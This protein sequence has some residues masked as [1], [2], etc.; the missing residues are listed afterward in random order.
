MHDGTLFPFRSSWGYLGG[1]WRL[2]EDEV[3]WSDLEDSTGII[4]SGPADVLVTVFRGRNRKQQALDDVPV[5]FK[6]PKLADHGVFMNVRSKKEKKALDKEIPYSKIAESDKQAYLEAEAK[7]WQSWL[8]YDAV[9][10]LSVEESQEILRTKRERVLKCR[11]VYRNKHAGLVDAA[12]NPLPLKPKARLCVQGQHDPDCMSGLVKLDAPTVQHTSFM[13]FLHLVVSYGWIDFLRNGDI[14]SAFLQGEETTGEPLYMF[15]PERGLPNLNAQQVLRL[16]RPVYGRP[17]APRAWYNQI[18][19]FIMNNMGYERSILDPALFVLRG[20]NN[21]PKGMLVL[22]V[23]DLLVATDGSPEAEEGVK[24]LH[25]RFPF[26]EWGL[27]KDQPSGITYCGKEVVVGLEEGKQV[28]QMRQRGFVEGR[29][30]TIQLTRERKQQVNELVT[31]Q[32]QSD[33]R[34]VLGALQWLSTQSRPDVSFGTNQLQK[35]VNSLT[36][37][38]LLA[39]NRLVK[40]V[41]QHE[42]CFTFRD[43]GKDVVVVSWHDAGLYN[44]V[45]VELDEQDDELVQSLADKKLLYSQKGCVVGLCRRADLERTDAVQANVL[46]WKSKTNRRI[47]ESSFSAEVQAALLGHSCGQYL[48]TLLLEVQH[49]S[50]IVKEDDQLDWHSLLPLLMV[51]DCKSVY[52]TIK[53]DGVSVDKSTAVSVAVLRQLCCSDIHPKGEKGSILWTPTRHQVADPLTKSGRHA[54]LQQ[55]LQCGR[56]VFHAVSSKSLFKSKRNLGQC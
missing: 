28:L 26:G 25:E 42:V 21:E 7:E 39:A 24:L 32:E 31:P 49:G 20:P 55:V 22:H 53:K 10:P 12:G 27:V 4:P 52:D 18:S 30:E 19:S 14:S 56:V 17:D 15:L 35:R 51:S 44:S 45:G 50:W 36:V 9:Q 23:D 38:D 41:K 33:F 1:Q 5:G 37:G 29:L 48:R 46:C 13:L 3:K 16:K 11:F 2:L 40:L 54:D 6:K 8:D 34:S 47:L 43:L